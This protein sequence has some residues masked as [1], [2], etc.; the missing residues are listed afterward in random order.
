MPTRAAAIAIAIVL[1]PMSAHAQE[2]QDV[3]M[4]IQE[5]CN[6]SNSIQNQL[7]GLFDQCVRESG[8]LTEECALVE[9]D[10]RREALACEQACARDPFTMLDSN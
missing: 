3:A 2:P 5:I 1:L 10:A 6:A 9:L 7:Y 4:C 8:G